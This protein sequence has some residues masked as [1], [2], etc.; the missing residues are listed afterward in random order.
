[1]EL[2]SGLKK[3][4]EK[5][6]TDID[7]IVGVPRCG[8]LPATLLALYWNKPLTDIYS[9]CGKSLYGSFVNPD[10]WDFGRVKKV[11]VMDDSIASG[12][13]LGKVKEMIAKA[14]LGVEVVYAALYT[15]AQTKGMVDYY[16][17]VVPHPRFWEWDITTAKYVQD[18]CV[19]IDGVLCRNPT[20]EEQSSPGKLAHFYNTVKPW[21]KPPYIQSIVTG[22]KEQY[23]PET[24]AWLNKHRIKYGELVMSPDED[25]GAE[26]H[27]RFKAQAY[28]KSPATLFVESSP[29][30]AEIIERT[31]KQVLV[32]FGETRKKLRVLLHIMNMSLPGGA[33]ISCCEILSALHRRGHDCRVTASKRAAVSWPQSGI[34]DLMSSQPV[35]T[36]YQWADVVLVHWFMSQEAIRLT[37]K[38]KVPRVHYICDL[39]SP[40]RF[41]LK[42]AG[43]LLFNSY[44][45]ME[46]T[47]WHGEQIVVHPPVYPE[48]FET[49]PGDGILLVTPDKAKGIAMFLKIAR[50]MPDRKFVIAK[51]R[52]REALKT[53][54][55]N[56]EFLPH[57]PDVRNVYSHARLV[58]MPSR[59]D[60]Y[61]SLK[62]GM[63]IWVE[64]YGRVAMEAACS[65]IPTIGSRE[66]KGLNECL[67][68]G[69][70][71][72]GQ[73]NVDEWVE[74][75]RK[76]DD[77]EFYKEKS[78]YYKN[79]VYSRHPDTEIAALE[80]KLYEIIG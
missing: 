2:N 12:R 10:R 76:L 48:I 44:W 22:R 63:T 66:S 3:L 31:G 33:S 54:P 14:D 73:D 58:L 75:I 35:E 27:G 32:P 41:G 38:I 6:P 42:D 26:K 13:N 25:V 28:S 5:L 18:A 71:F 67:G 15:T 59:E 34:K 43:L 52:T 57:L 23:R 21:I 56:V 8:M 46:D 4:L 47:K 19:D 37:T 16:L 53:L 20:R 11:L 45:L 60:R 1:M 62:H 70:L 61:N 80:E 51:G 79:L 36:L 7:L 17:E 64:G 50:K 9:L 68:E 69:G 72:A 24:E 65:G 40:R 74:M 29:I 77:P 39:D 49:T 55:D 78:E 30:E